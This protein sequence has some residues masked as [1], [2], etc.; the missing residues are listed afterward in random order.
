MYVLSL[1]FKCYSEYNPVCKPRYNLHC[2]DFSKMRQLI[3]DVDWE[4]DLNPLHLQDAWHYFST[5]FDDIVAK[6]I[7]LDLRI[8]EK[9]LYD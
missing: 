5:V 7:P 3:S 9:Y 2:A 8:Q 1:S 6:C 4:N